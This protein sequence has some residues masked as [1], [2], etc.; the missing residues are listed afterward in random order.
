M[1]TALGRGLLVMVVFA[2]ALA[3]AEAALVRPS[4]ADAQRG[5]H[6]DAQA[7]TP[8]DLKVKTQILIMVG[9]GTF[10]VGDRG[11]EG[12]G[13]FQIIDNTTKVPKTILSFGT[14][15]A[16]SLVSYSEVG[17]YGAYAAGTAV[18][19][20]VLSLSAGTRVPATLTVVC[21]IGPAGLINPG[22][23]EEG[24]SV[25]IGTTSFGPVAGLTIFDTIG[26]D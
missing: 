5:F 10:E 24:I 14:W 17:T 4:R 25:V 1:K 15:Q 8:M 20:I 3:T 12:G 23:P 16:R 21:N 9:T 26:E 18:M 11:A 6:F 22:A 19:N 7:G 2:L 13:V